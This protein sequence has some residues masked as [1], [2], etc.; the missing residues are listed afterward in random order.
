M[1]P[2]HLSDK[3]SYHAK[4]AL[5]NAEALA[6]DSRV[7]AVTAKHLFLAL[8]EEK[9]SLGN[10][11]FANAGLKK[12]ARNSQKDPLLHPLVPPL[13]KKKIPERK[14]GA[15]RLPL[16]PHMKEI[17][18]RAYLVA[19]QFHSPYVGTEHLAYALLDNP[20]AETMAILGAEGVEENRL[21]DSLEAHL[22]FENFPNF[23]KMLDLPDVSIAKKTQIPSNTIPFLSQYAVDLGEEARERGEILFGREQETDRLI[24]ILG[25]K[26]KNNPLLLGEPGVGK[27]AIVAA[28]AKATLEGTVPS[29][30]AGKRIFALDLA[31]VVAGTSFRGE[32]EARLKEIVREASTQKD[33]ILFIDEIH[34]IIGAGNTQGGLDAANILKPA[35]ARGDMR[36]IG[37]TTLSEYKRYIEKDPALDRRFQTIF[38]RE[39][40]PEETKKLLRRV[41]RTY[42]SFHEVSISPALLDL[43]VDMSVRHCHERFLPD[44]ALDILDEA[45]SLA[46]NRR[47]ATLSLRTAAALEGARKNILNEKELRF[48]KHGTVHGAFAQHY[49]KTKIFDEKYHKLL[50]G[51][52]R[53]R[54]LGDYDEVTRFAPEEVLQIL[55]QAADFLNKAKEYLAKNS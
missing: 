42:E 40:T 6:R 2:S 50:T 53:R 35:L 51:S 24:R 49:I 17:L 41:R 47:G 28:L 38:V 34:T 15:A 48:S 13:P 31:L 19:S 54:M 4:Q 25:R 22:G 12:N 16:S 1:I 20:D 23:G 45:S 27:T 11:F 14:K 3:L 52:F 44:K 18:S 55:E 5:R 30:L 8:L 26:N 33:I 7:P 36:I 39:Q 10:L 9:G 46:K 32:F 29:A 37:A 43:A 21:L